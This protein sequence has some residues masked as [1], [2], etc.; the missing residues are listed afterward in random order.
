MAKPGQDTPVRRTGDPSV[1]GHLALILTHYFY[2]DSRLANQV[3]LRYF[4]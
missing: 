4:S 1:N 2:L 3:W